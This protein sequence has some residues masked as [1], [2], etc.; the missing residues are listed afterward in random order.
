MARSSTSISE[1]LPD[2]RSRRNTHRDKGTVVHSGSVPKLE[3]PSVLESNNWRTIEKETSTSHSKK[4][5]NLTRA[6]VFKYDRTITAKM[7]LRQSGGLAKKYERKAQR[8]KL[9]ERPCTTSLTPIPPRIC[10]FVNGKEKEDRMIL[11]RHPAVQD[12]PNA[13]HSISQLCPSINNKSINYRPISFIDLTGPLHSNFWSNHQ[14]QQLYPSDPESLEPVANGKYPK[15]EHVVDLTLDSSTQ[16]EPFKRS[17]VTDSRQ[18]GSARSHSSN[19]ATYGSHNQTLLSPELKHWM[20]FNPIKHIVLCSKD[21]RDIS[22]GIYDKS[23][24]IFSIS[25]DITALLN[26]KIDN[27]NIHSVH[28]K[29]HQADSPIPSLGNTNNMHGY[30]SKSALKFV[31]T[32][33][34]AAIADTI[35]LVSLGIQGISNSPRAWVDLRENS[36]AYK[37]LVAIQELGNINSDRGL[38]W[39][40]TEKRTYLIFPLYQLVRVCL[41]LE[42]PCDEA[43]LYSEYMRL[44][45]DARKALRKTEASVGSGNNANQ[46]A[47]ALLSRWACPIDGCG[48]TWYR[49]LA[50]DQEWQTHCMVEHDGFHKLVCPLAACRSRVFRDCKGVIEHIENVHI[51][52]LGLQD[53]Y[54]NSHYRDRTLSDFRST[55]N[56]SK[57][58]NTRCSYTNQLAL[59]TH[60]EFFHPYSAWKDRLKDFPSLA[61]Q[62]QSKWSTEDLEPYD[63][64]ALSEAFQF[65]DAT[66]GSQGTVIVE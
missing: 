1:S 14:S 55:E 63:G 19:N 12:E 6:D 34:S 40:I 46:H 30:S 59:D 36:P 5:I 49:S 7:T 28:L 25:D 16:Q 53:H 26:I 4:N 45:N 41:G 60:V 50:G 47:R 38:L 17:R 15:R 8:T 58:G 42:S 22:D 24:A 23:S 39:R 33:R 56:I 29:D 3:Y 65:I 11:A 31:S 20:S 62:I 32:I 2:F 48:M 18:S 54:R 10:S 57:C 21:S 13:K 64:T 37:F 61:E 66:V 43:K 27:T 52:A 51:A 35:L 9:P 44:S